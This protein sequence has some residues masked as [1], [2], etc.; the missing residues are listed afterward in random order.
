MNTYN[1]AVRDTLNMLYGVRKLSFPSEKIT[2]NTSVAKTTLVSVRRKILPN[3]LANRFGLLVSF[4]GTAD[5]SAMILLSAYVSRA[6][7]PE[8]LRKRG[9]VAD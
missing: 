6:L 8:S 5:V 1:A 3:T 7:M 2:N 4:F 9:F